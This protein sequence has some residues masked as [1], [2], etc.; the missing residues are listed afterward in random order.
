M[1]SIAPVSAGVSPL[2]AAEGAS[3][4]LSSRF[5]Q[6]LAERYVTA[7][8]ERD[9]ILAAA[10]DPSVAAD[11]ARL[12]ALQLRLDEYTKQIALSSSLVSHA[13]KGIETLVKS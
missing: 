9:A 13:T 11:P 4:P 8:Q 10:N 5:N 7:G 6:A 12:H 3:V 1:I 2:A